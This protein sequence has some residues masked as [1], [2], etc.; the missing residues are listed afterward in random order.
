MPGK[1]S[2]TGGLRYSGESFRPSIAQRTT[3]ERV[4]REGSATIEL[5]TVSPPIES[6][7]TGPAS[8]RRIY[9]LVADDFAAV[10]ALIPRRLTSDVDLVE[11]ISRYIVESGGKRVRP[12]LVLLCA[13]ALSFRGDAH[14]KLAAIIEF[15]H[16]ATLLHDDVVDRSELRRGRRTANAVWGNAPTVLVGDFLY[17]RAFQLMTELGDLGVITILSDAT[18]RIAEGEV[19]QLANVGRVDLDEAQYVEVI[20]AKTAMLFRA[21]THT[22]AVLVGGRSNEIEALRDYGEFLGLAYQL[23]DDWLDYAGDPTLMGKNAG[24]DLAE[25]KVTLP[26]IHTLRNGSPAE[27][28]C[29]REAIRSRASHSLGD[30]LAAV[31]QSGALDYTRDQAGRF[32]ERARSRLECIPRSPYRDAL[33]ALA[34]YCVSRMS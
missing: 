11:E 16:T 20:R 9:E 34:R 33:D 7:P 29:V 26:L 8:L 14:Q 2:C 30:V 31:R 19:H 6:A 4:I 22:A 32:A 3:R 13:R 10:N 12:L 1:A 17:S 23:V 5:D 18:N 28:R 21:A 25:G 15:L 24:D 27:A